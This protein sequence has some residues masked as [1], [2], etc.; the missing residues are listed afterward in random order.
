[1]KLLAYHFFL[2]LPL[3][4]NDLGLLVGHVDLLLGRSFLLLHCGDPDLQLADA[5]LEHLSLLVGVVKLPLL[6]VKVMP[7]DDLKAFLVLSYLFRFQLLF[8][9]VFF[10][11]VISM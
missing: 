7:S 3:I 9:S 11:I 8:G 2:T 6:L 4:I 1:M 10:L 5:E